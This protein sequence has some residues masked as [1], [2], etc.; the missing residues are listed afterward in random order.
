[1]KKILLLLTLAC[2]VLFSVSSLYAQDCPS[3]SGTTTPAD[4]CGTF[5]VTIDPANCV[6]AYGDS[7]GYLLYYDFDVSTTPTQEE[8]YDDLVGNVDLPD[9]AW[10]GE[11]SPC[12]G[13]GFID[14]EAI[15]IGCTTQDV[16]FYLIPA[17]L[18]ALTIDAECAIEGP[19]ISTVYPTFS[20]V[21]T[22]A[23]DCDVPA[24]VELQGLDGTVCETLTGATVTRPDCTPGFGDNVNVDTLFVVYDQA[25]LAAIAGGTPPADCFGEGIDGFVAAACASFACEGGGCQVANLEL[26]GGTC[27]NNGT[28][29][30]PTDDFY[31]IELTFNYVDGTTYSVSDATSG[32]V[33]VSG[34]TY[35]DPPSQTEVISFTIP[36]NGQSV[37]LTVTDASGA[38]CTVS[39]DEIGP[40][41][42]CSDCTIFSGSS[43][44]SPVCAG[45]EEGVFTVT[46]GNCDI[47]PDGIFTSAILMYDLDVT[48][49]PPTDEDLYLDVTGNVPMDDLVYFGESG[50]CANEGGLS[51]LEG[52]EN[53]SCTPLEI[54]LYLMPVNDAINTVSFACLVEGPIRLTTLPGQPTAISASCDAGALTSVVTLG[55]DNGDGTEDGAPDG[56]FDDPEDEVCGTV[57]ISVDDTG[58]GTV[59]A[60]DFQTGLGNS[61]DYQGNNCYVDQDVTCPCAAEAPGFA[62]GELCD[63]G[64]TYAAPPYI[65]NDVG[66]VEGIGNI[67]EYLLLDATSIILD[68]TSN[69]ADI[70]AAMDALAEGESLCL[71]SITHS[72]AQLNTIFEDLN[73]PDCS[74]TLVGTLT[75]ITPPLNTLEQLF[76]GFVVLNM[77]NP[78]LTPADLE[79]FISDNP[80]GPSAGGIPIDIGVLAGLPEGILVCT[81]PAFCYSL[82]DPICLTKE[83]NGAS[84]NV[85]GCT[86]P[87]ATNYDMDATI[88]DGSCILPEEP[89]T[90]CYETATFNTTSCMWEVSGTQP[91]APTTECYE[92][93]T[94]NDGTCMWDVSGTQPE[95]PAL[96]CYETAEFNTTTCVWDVSGTQPE[97]PATEC[98][99]T[100]TFNDGTCSWDV[101]G[102]Q[103][104]PPELACYESTTFNT[105]TCVW[106]VTGE[107]PEIDDNCEFTDD[108]FDDVNCVAVNVSNCPAGTTLNTV[109]CTCDTDV[110]EGCTDPCASNYDA[111][112]N[113]DDGSCILP[114]EPTTACY[115]TATFNTT[116]CMWEV[117]G[118]QPE[119]PT[120]ACYETATFNDATC[121]WDVSGE[122]PEAPATACYETATFNDGTCSWDVSGTQPEQPELACYETANF[123]DITCV[124]DVGGEQPEIDDNCEFT[125]DSFDDV[126][127]V[128]VNVSNCPAGTTL[129]TVN[130]TC[131]SD[132]VM[133]CTDPCASNYDS[134][135]TADDGSCILPEEPT[136]ACYETAAFNTT[137]CMWEVSGE[138][139]EI[140]DNCDLTDDSFDDVNCVAVNTPNCPAGT[141]FDAANCA[142][143]S[144]PVDGCTDDTACNFDPNATN[145]DGSCVFA[146][147][148]DECDGAGGVTDNPEE[149]TACDDG[150]PDTENDAIQADCTCA[151]DPIMG[152]AMGCTDANACN[153]NPMATMDD[154]SCEYTSCADCEG[155]PNGS[156]T[157]GSACDDGNPD[158]TGDT[159]QE[160]CS[161][162]GSLLR[163]GCTDAMACNYDPDAEADDGSCVLPGD[164]CNDGNPLTINDTVQADCTC[165][166]EDSGEAIPTVGEWGLIILALILLNLGVLYIRQTDIKIVRE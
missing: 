60:A 15:P 93:A 34:Q 39:L 90:A 137:S 161:C 120:T 49:T 117:S 19:I 56:D 46:I 142:C 23:A 79:A 57:T 47:A 96:A 86:N 70:Q 101:S 102:T 136:T 45:A 111:T 43:V 158:T 130:C 35:A 145:D 88:D 71:A 64:V 8:I 125:D 42:T 58:V 44:T 7:S 155:T 118:T 150:N 128:A 59:S 38:A 162:T 50:T 87:C 6:T 116:S 17:N 67:T 24:I 80:G 148:C 26:T 149:G 156:A 119:A 112:A 81:V 134:S 139:P 65:V 10:L 36:A 40:L 72:P 110:I 92:T 48:N 124:W 164:S 63:D 32:T 21:V 85:E 131:D 95:Q 16:A 151:G 94:F 66:A 61:G 143:T 51:N 37:V 154:G 55:F 153:Y 113:S 73:G 97:A 103:P 31:D 12:D 108:S 11:R 159:Y 165:I 135:A 166:G 84:C 3:T 133:G 141:T 121:V 122:Q 146:T 68:V 9:A 62:L 114:E 53:P 13:S 107:Q 147:G 77:G 115:E 157:P 140:D 160:D 41:D 82:T 2:T 129:N 28:S 98:Y 109:D 1:M 29:T 22:Q 126:N 123:N 4:I 99:E 18:T 144:E 30:D 5:T 69:L 132:V 91:E 25:A 100:A 138:Q 89:T 163:M 83:A 33:Y 74:N 104:E 54:D 14:L 27:N 78:G 106:D 20:A 127:C 76:D 52:F 152:G 75:G 105:T